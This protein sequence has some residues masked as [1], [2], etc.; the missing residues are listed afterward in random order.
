MFKFGIWQ[1]PTE[2]QE[3]GDYYLLGVSPIDLGKLAIS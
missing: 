2:D 3:F 1:V